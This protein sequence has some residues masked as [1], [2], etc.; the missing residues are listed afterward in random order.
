MVDTSHEVFKIVAMGAI[1]FVSQL[2]KATVPRKK[3]TE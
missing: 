3:L 2:Q 1:P